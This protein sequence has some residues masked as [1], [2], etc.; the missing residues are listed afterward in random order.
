MYR[1][2]Q[3]ALVGTVFS[4]GVY[5]W[6]YRFLKNQ[7]SRM[8]KRETFSNVE[9]TMITAIAGCISSICSNPIW[10]LN[11][12][13]TL[14]KPDKDG[15]TRGALEVIADV[16]EK[17]GIGAFFKGVIPNLILVINPI[18]NFVIYE[19]LRKYAIKKYGSERKVP[20]RATFAMSSVGKIAATFATYP[21]LTFRVKL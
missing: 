11:T 1:G 19:S 18:I 21:I 9:V 16:I 12:R 5:F 10:F 14:Q 2:L 3:A 8:L 15:K 17:E 6:W 7:V 20:N 13:M 4:F